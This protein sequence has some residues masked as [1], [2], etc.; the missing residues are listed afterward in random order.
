MKKGNFILCVL[1]IIVFY[2]LHTACNFAEK[3]NAYP[4][5]LA[6][7]DSLGNATE[8][9][10][11]LQL[12][13]NYTSILSKDS[14]DDLS[15]LKLVELYINEARVTGNLT[16]YNNASMKVLSTILNRKM[17]SKDIRYQALAYK[18]TILLSL[19]QF[20]EAKKVAQ[21]AVILNPYDADIYGALVDANVEIGDYAEAVKM[22]DKMMSIRPDIRSYS[23][24][25][26]I[27]QLHGDNQG[28]IQ[29]MRLAVESG[30]QG[31]ENTEWARVQLGDLYLNTGHADTAK[32]LYES[33]LYARPNYPYAEMGLSKMYA[34]EK[35]YDE[36]I[37]HCK[38]A[39]RLMS[40]ASFISYMGELYKLKGDIAK[41]NEVHKD[42]LDLTLEGEAENEKEALAKHNGNRE[43]A[44]A[45]LH[46]GKYNEALQFAQKDLAMRPKNMDANELV[47]WIY[48][49]KNDHINAKKHINEA[50]A[51]NTQQASLLYKASLIYNKA[52]ETDKALVL[53]N[54]ALNINTAFDTTP[55]TQVNKT[56][57]SNQ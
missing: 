47:A 24:T 9:A 12:Y 53:N 46:V 27:R 2:S 28:A 45:Y 23:R 54:S 21:E 50:M 18:A 16:Y 14:N 8:G 13:K 25:S 5:I 39:I 1:C 20:V 35:K 7:K 43:I 22:C 31:Q 11:L 10:T 48:F 4:T 29:A 17:T 3:A 15:R 42:V 34:T 30:A 52:G 49:L 55:Y 44:Q 38:N 37:T 32:M 26:Y 36:A 33:A 40:E 6:R 51:L 56:L 41:A 19:H 57:T